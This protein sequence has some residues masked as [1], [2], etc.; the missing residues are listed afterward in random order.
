MKA[1]IYQY[2]TNVNSALAFVT[3]NDLK[4]EVRKLGD[5]VSIALDELSELN[6]AHQKRPYLPDFISTMRKGYMSSVRELRAQIRT[7]CAFLQQKEAALN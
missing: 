3:I 5:Q 7:I 2:D 1:T 6:A 4:L